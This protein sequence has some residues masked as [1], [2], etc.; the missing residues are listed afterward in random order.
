MHTIAN[1]GIK[2]FNKDLFDVLLFVQISTPKVLGRHFFSLLKERH[3]WLLCKNLG[4]GFCLRYYRITHALHQQEVN[5][6]CVVIKALDLQLAGRL[7]FFFVPTALKQVSSTM[8]A[9][10]FLIK[11]S[12]HTGQP[13]CTLQVSQAYLK[14]FRKTVIDIGSKVLNGCCFICVVIRFAI[15]AMYF[16]SDVPYFVNVPVKRYVRYLAAL[17]LTGWMTFRP[18]SSRRVQLWRLSSSLVL[19]RDHELKTNSLVK[20]IF[21]LLHAWK[22][23][24]NVS[25]CLLCLLWDSTK[26][27]LCLDHFNHVGFGA[28][29]WL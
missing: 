7:Y 19:K 18:F 26:L 8:D 28:S 25:R 1:W 27:S 15:L 4:L 10:L 6:L 24:Y 12:R 9:T 20:D 5:Y 23:S 16:E 2:A 3:F 29:A 21:R 17:W 13:L 22:E 11:W 14:L